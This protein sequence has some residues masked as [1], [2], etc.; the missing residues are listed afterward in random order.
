MWSTVLS[1]SVVSDSLQPHGL[2]PTRLL[3]PGIFQAKTQEWVAISSSSNLPNPGSKPALLH[4]RWILHLL[5]YWGK[6]CNI[7][8][9]ILTTASFGQVHFEDQVS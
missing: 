6:P 9:V 8:M 2:Q 3:C 7:W 5:S 4:C 1:C